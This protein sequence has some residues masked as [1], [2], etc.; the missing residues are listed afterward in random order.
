MLREGAAS[1]RLSHETF[2]ARME[3]AVHARH[4]NELAAIVC[5]LRPVPPPR[6]TAVLLRA[7]SAW[8]GFTAAARGAWQAPR[9]P[10]LVLPRG[11]RLTYTIGRSGDCDLVIAD[12]TVSGHHAEL[13]RAGNGWVLVDVGSLNGTRVNGWRAGNGWPMHAGDL[14]V[15]GRARLRVTD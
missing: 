9:L 5:D 14:V 6:R 13:R 8:S 7:V 3:A 12:P 4:A 15:L 2:V 1:G 11:G 10:T